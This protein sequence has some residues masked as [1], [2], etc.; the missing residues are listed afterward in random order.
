MFLKTLIKTSIT[1]FHHSFSYR[2][3]HCLHKIS[4]R[5]NQIH[6]NLSCNY[7]DIKTNE[8]LLFTKSQETTIPSVLKIKRTIKSAGTY[9]IHDGFSCIESKCPACDFRPTLKSST[10]NDGCVSNPICINKTTG[11]FIVK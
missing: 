5:N 3:W 1:N 8:D 4:R 9:E 11:G 10:G 2:Q 6:F 7:C